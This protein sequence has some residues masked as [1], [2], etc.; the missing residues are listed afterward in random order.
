MVLKSFTLPVAIKGSGTQPGVCAGT[1]DWPKCHTEV[2]DK[3]YTK[4]CKGCDKE[5]N[6]VMI[7]QHMAF[8]QIHVYWYNFQEDLWYERET[9]FWNQGPSRW[10]SMR[11]VKLKLW[12]GH[13]NLLK[14][15][16][17]S[18]NKRL[19]DFPS[20]ECPIVHIILILTTWVCRYGQP[21]VSASPCH[22]WSQNCRAHICRGQQ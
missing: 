10:A 7:T 19:E 21:G 15:V 4:V 14:K 17:R 18:P 5:L 13:Q 1:C 6:W 8:C 11:I 3:F 2:P 20:F 12:S 9:Y 22:G 16:A